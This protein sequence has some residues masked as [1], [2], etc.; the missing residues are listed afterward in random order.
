MV[1]SPLGFRIC[2]AR[3]ASIANGGS[4]SSRVGVS[5]ETY[6][7]SAAVAAMAPAP[8]AVAST[9]GLGSG[10]DPGCGW[11][12]TDGGLP[13]TGASNREGAP[14]F[15]R[16]EAVARPSGALGGRPSGPGGTAGGGTYDSGTGRAAPTTGG[17][18]RSAGARSGGWI[19]GCP[20]VDHIRWP[21]SRET[22]S[23]SGSALSG[24]FTRGSSYL[25]SSCTCHPYPLRIVGQH[26]VSM[27]VPARTAER[28]ARR[29]RSGPVRPTSARPTLSTRGQPTGDGH[30]G[31]IVVLD[32]IAT[33]RMGAGQP[34]CCRC[35]PIRRVRAL[36]A[37][38]PPGGG[39]GP[40][41]S[42]C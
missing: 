2:T 19:V 14:A 24:R 12:G 37:C 15:R 21:V 20:P 35:D 11:V 1:T 8:V 3:I 6:A 23:G 38:R 9:T 40:A 27:A 7:A 32:G 39:S 10:T 25:P 13:V 28:T 30:G 18:R 36:A 22:G 4:S 33:D 42:P 16:T 26:P 41:L 17:S 5:R 29:G 31:S 34:G